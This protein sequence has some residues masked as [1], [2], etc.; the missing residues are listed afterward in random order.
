MS[1]EVPTKTGTVAI[2]LLL[3]YIDDID[4][5]AAIKAV[6]ADQRLYDG[7]ACPNAWLCE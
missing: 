3:C 7:P 1:P 6:G 4:A 5:V 2:G